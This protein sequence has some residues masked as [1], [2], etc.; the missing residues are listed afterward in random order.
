MAELAMGHLQKKK[1]KL[2]CDTNWIGGSTGEPLMPKLVE[3]LRKK[4]Q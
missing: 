3:Y 2:L 4:S 1:K